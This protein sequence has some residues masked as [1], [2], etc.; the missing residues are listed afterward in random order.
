QERSFLLL[1]A[2]YAGQALERLRLLDAE[3][4]SRMQSSAAATRLEI[5][6]RTSRA[7]VAS[8]LDRDRRLRHIAGELAMALDG[9]VEIRL[10]GRDSLLR[11]AA[12]HPA[13]AARPVEPTGVASEV[14]LAIA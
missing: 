4:K 2:G 12:H 1:I 9:S 6:N 10:F 13:E 11:V 14:P 5:L 3:S 7:F 8:D